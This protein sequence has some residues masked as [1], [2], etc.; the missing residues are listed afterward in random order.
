MTFIPVVLIVDDGQ[1]G[2]NSLLLVSRQYDH[3]HSWLV[4]LRPLALRSLHRLLTWVASSGLTPWG[5]SNTRPATSI[6]D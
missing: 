6:P 4:S 1:T 5:S 3:Q 2:R